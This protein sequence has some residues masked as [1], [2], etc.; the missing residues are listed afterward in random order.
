M[1]CPVVRI[2]TIQDIEKS[3]LKIVTALVDETKLISFVAGD[4]Y[5]VK[6]LGFIIS[7]GALLPEKLLRE[8]WLWNDTTGKGR[9]SGKLGNRSKSRKIDGVFSEY[10]FYG[11]TYLHDGK[12]I[13]SPSWNQNWQ[14][15]HDVSEELGIAFQAKD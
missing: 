15:G 8:M 6:Q 2:T 14:L 9:L 1:K 11:A 7:E 5:E 4:H 10:L 12:K 13:D 3:K